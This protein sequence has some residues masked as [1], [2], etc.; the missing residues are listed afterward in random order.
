MDNIRVAV[1]MGGI[2]SEREVSLRSGAK[3]AQALARDKYD[4]STLD[5]T[6]D[7]APLVALKGK[8]DVVFL[9]LHGPGGEDGRV[10]GLLDLLDLP[11]TGSGVLG[12]A[13]AM[14]KDVAKQLFRQAGIP[15]PRSLSLDAF[16]GDTA[17]EL[18]V[19]QVRDGIGLPCVIKPANEGS[20]IGISIARDAAAL[21]AGIA[22]AF[23]YDT[24]LVVEEFIAGTEISVSVLGTTAPRALPDIEIVP[25]SGFYDYTMKYTPGATEEICPARISDAAHATAAE[26]ALR[27][28]RV[29]HCR[30]VSRSDMIVTGEA[31]TVLETNTLPGLTETS[32][33]PLAARIAGISFPDLCDFL[34]G[35]ALSEGGE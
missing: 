3:V 1:V 18:Q 32:L 31:V 20:T 15:T 12:S 13:V 4:V 27:A 2:S 25:R 17:L 10:Q 22:D 14:H 11:Y 28:H 8:V 23:L 19:A 5:F 7:I 9:A 6:G 33:L 16:A 30:G 35:E 26:Y 24:E 34:I 29:L 21:E